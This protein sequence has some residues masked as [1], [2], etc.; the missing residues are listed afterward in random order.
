MIESIR[1]NKEAIAAYDAET[2]VEGV[3]DMA[4][5]NIPTQIDEITTWSAIRTDHNAKEV[6]MEMTLEGEASDYEGIEEHL[7]SLREGMV[8]S[9]REGRASDWLILVST[10]KGYSLGYDYVLTDG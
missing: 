7:A 5:L 8:E 2:L 4:R 3:A 6:V 10:E 1:V 9:L